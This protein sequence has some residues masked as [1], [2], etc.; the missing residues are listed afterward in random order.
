MVGTFLRHGSNLW[1]ALGL[2]ALVAGFAAGVFFAALGRRRR[3]DVRGAR[4]R[5]DRTV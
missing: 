4:T 3:L 2:V 1:L 5:R